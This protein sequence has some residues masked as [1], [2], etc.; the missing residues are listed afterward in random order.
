MSFLVYPTIKESPILSM[1]GMGGGGTG[2]ALGGGGGGLF[3]EGSV[4][5]TISS[6]S[7]SAWDGGGYGI[8]L[9]DGST[10]TAVTYNDSQAPTDGSLLIPN[11]AD[12]FNLCLQTST[13]NMGIGRGSSW[14]RA[15]IYFA[16]PINIKVYGSAGNGGG[17]GCWVEY[18]GGSTALVSSATNANNVVRV[19]AYHQS[20]I[21]GASITQIARQD[22]S[23]LFY[24]SGTIDTN[25]LM[26]YGS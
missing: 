9:N 21:A 14:G 2:T 15:D 6:Q 11:S 22:G 5:V 4:Q 24:E 3:P 18:S 16:S 23:K 8:S 17:T 19:W 25:R 7:N 13:G 10:T 1:L 20:G 12:R 26:A